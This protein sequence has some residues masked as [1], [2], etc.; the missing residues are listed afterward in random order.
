MQKVKKTY[1]WYLEIAQ[2][3]TRYHFSTLSGKK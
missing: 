3:D 2:E 1:Q